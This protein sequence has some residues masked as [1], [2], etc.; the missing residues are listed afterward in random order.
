[1][2]TY[3][4]AEAGAC[5]DGDLDKALQLVRV[6]AA[7]GADA[8]K[9]QFVSSAERL[10]ERRGAL[11]FLAAY[12]V[13]QFPVEWHAV[14][15]DACA[16][17]GIDYLCTV[18]LPEDIAVVAPYVAR[19]KLSSFEAQD[20]VFVEAHRAYRKPV[21]MSTGMQGDPPIRV[22]V[23]M[24]LLHCTSA[25]PTPLEEMNLGAIREYGLE[26]LSDHSGHVEMGGLA[27]AAGA[28]IIET[29]IKLETTN[30]E[31][32]DAGPHALNAALYRIYVERA[33]R[34]EAIMGDGIKRV[35][36]SET[37]MAKYLVKGVKP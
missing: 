17:A 2:S 13:I 29:H 27:V 31:N 4:I 15:R 16:T 8:C 24:A 6:A 1:M 22:L 3:L 30:S 14:L 36:P 34:A 18:Y 37:E 23:D 25:Y 5:H 9:F 7:C 12:R 33:R 32:P 19:F 10:A 21:I 28:R 20:H 35:Q 11:D 26:G